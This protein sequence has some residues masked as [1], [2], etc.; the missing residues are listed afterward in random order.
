[1]TDTLLRDGAK[2]FVDAFDQLLGVISRKR[3]EV[4]G[5]QKV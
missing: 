4:L 5:A 3:E 1:V 2:L